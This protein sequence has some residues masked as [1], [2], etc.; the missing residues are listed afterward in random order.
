MIFTCDSY[1]SMWGNSCLYHVWYCT[2]WFIH[3]YDGFSKFWSFSSYISSYTNHID[4]PTHVN[5]I[6]VWKNFAIPTNSRNLYDTGMII[7]GE[8]YHRWIFDTVLVSIT[9]Q[10]NTNIH[11]YYFDYIAHAYTAVM[12][13]KLIKFDKILKKCAWSMETI[14]I[15]LKKC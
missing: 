7:R 6:H 10:L 11:D 9:N 15:L 8:R 2:T 5:H 12:H 14:C 3:V 4:R 1:T 13:I